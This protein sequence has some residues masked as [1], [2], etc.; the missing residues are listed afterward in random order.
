MMKPVVVAMALVFAAGTLY[1][2]EYEVKKKAGEYDV[3]V[4]IDHN[5]PV[6][7]DNTV[8][9]GIKDAAGH[10]VKDAK[11]VVDYSMPA[12]PGMPP[13]NYKADAVQKGDGY[14]A[15]MNLSMAGP[16]NIEVK[17]SQTG[18]TGKLKFTIDVK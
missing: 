5:P 17:I 15:T 18:K 6:T 11:V 16:W 3:V 9:I 2:G 14:K 10:Q 13:M 4:K 7:G 12:M 8:S 1:A